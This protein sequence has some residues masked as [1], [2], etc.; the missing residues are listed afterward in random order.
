MKLS[1]VNDQLRTGMDKG[2]VIVDIVQYQAILFASG[3][4]AGIVYPHD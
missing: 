2:N 3:H 4:E 1:A